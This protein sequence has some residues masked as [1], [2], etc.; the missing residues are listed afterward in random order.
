MKLVSTEQSLQM[1][2]DRPMPSNVSGLENFALGERKEEEKV[3][4]ADSLFNL[5]KGDA[6]E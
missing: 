1:E 4:D 2:E 3:I 6:E 5:P